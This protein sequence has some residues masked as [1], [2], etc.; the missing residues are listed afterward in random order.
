MVTKQ[1]TLEQAEQAATAAFKAAE[2]V[3]PVGVPEIAE[4]LGVKADTVHKWRRRNG[5][6]LGFPDAA[7]IVAGNVPVWE[8][9]D[10]MVW[11]VER[12]V[13]T[14]TAFKKPE[15]KAA[16]K[17]SQP[18]GRAKKSRAQPPA[19]APK[20]GTPKAAGRAAASAKSSRKRTA[21]PVVIGGEGNPATLAEAKAAQT[22]DGPASLKALLP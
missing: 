20:S 3:D 7:W 18:T 9:A 19:K 15:R 12:R 11:V 5:G 16:A 14:P 2:G 17:P 4:R 21:K 22:S 6:S 10:V 13:D 8:W 1:I